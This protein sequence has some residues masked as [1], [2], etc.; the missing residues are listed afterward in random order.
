[1]AVVSPRGNRIPLADETVVDIGES[2]VTRDLSIDLALVRSPR[3]DLPTRERGLGRMYLHFVEDPA[4]VE[5][6]Y[7][8]AGLNAM[9]IDFDELA[10]RILAQTLETS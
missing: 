2:R 6:P 1:M 10:W 4:I 9:G 3:D 7:F 8:E 5:G